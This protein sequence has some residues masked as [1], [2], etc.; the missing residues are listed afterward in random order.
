V[1][2]AGDS[3]NTGFLGSLAAEGFLNKAFIRSISESDT[4]M[5]MEF[6]AHVAEIMVGGAGSNPRW[7]H[8]L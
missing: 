1:S 2:R 8:K 7:K 4:I 3:F 6:G 5:A